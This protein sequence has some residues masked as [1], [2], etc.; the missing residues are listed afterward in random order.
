MRIFIR[1]KASADL[2]SQALFISF[3]NA[4]MAYQL[5][6][7]CEE[8][9]KRLAKM[10]HLGQIYPTGKKRLLGIR[11]FPIAGFER[12]FIFYVPLKDRIDI[13]RILYS[14]QDIT[15]IIK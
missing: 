5:C 1:P 3:D 15:R 14:R 11:F 13:V 2:E 8:T 6:E 9:F 12:H 7:A 4:R 10:P